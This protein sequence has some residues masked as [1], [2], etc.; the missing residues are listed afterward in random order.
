MAAASDGH[1]GRQFRHRYQWQHRNQQQLGELLRAKRL[2]HMSTLVTSEP[3]DQRR[4]R[5][6]AN[7]GERLRI[8]PLAYAVGPLL[9]LAETAMRKC[10]IQVWFEIS[11]LWLAFQVVSITTG[12][13][14]DTLNWRTN[15]ALV[16]ADIKDGQL[17]WLLEEITSATG[18]RVFVEP[19][20]SHTVSAKFENLSPGEALRL[21]LGD[22]NFALVPTANASPKP[23]VFR[24]TVGNAT[25]R[26]V[27]PD[28]A[29]LHGPGEASPERTR[30]RDHP[31]RDRPGGSNHTNNRPNGD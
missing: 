26:V 16:S 24:T 18:W 21:L 1:L 13:A 31:D 7:A 17:P 10:V 23:F 5:H 27:I 28:S 8:L 12:L 30:R 29:R 19:D 6:G 15:A 20:V 9:I 4:H 11:T 14:A 22:L 2:Q 25:Q 3:L